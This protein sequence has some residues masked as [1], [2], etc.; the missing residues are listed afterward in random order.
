M[1]AAVVTGSVGVPASTFPASSPIRQKTFDEH[2]RPVTVLYGSTV[3]LD[4][5]AASNGGVAEV[6]TLPLSSAAMH[7]ELVE[8]TSCVTVLFES[9]LAEEGADQLA[10]ANGAVAVSTRPSESIAM[11]AVLEGHAS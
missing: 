2:A 1:G 8:H 4:Q 6:S 3:E 11:H 9:M 7:S 5:D 10:A